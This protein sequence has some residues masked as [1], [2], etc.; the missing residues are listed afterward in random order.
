MKE[1][2]LLTDCDGVMLDWVTRF[3]YWMIEKH[4]FEIVKPNAWKADHRFGIKPDLARELVYKFNHSSWIGFLDPLYDAQ[5]GI[6]Q[7][8]SKGWKLVVITSLS[9]DPYSWKAR[10]QNLENLFGKDAVK[11]LICL[12]T[13]ADKEDILRKWK[14]SG[15]WWIEDKPANAV[16]GLKAGLKPLLMHGPYTEGFE[17]EGIKRVFS[18]KEVVNCIE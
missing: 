10:M 4:G 14:D 12:E 13:G 16:E 3:N 6:A 1:K 18:W 15:L 17:R 9:T 8:V 2:I 7:L 11:D 5:E